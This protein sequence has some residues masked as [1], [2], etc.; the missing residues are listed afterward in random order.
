MVVE[1]DSAL[2]GKE[3]AEA[4]FRESGNRV[5]EGFEELLVLGFGEGKEAGALED[6]EEGEGDTCG[7]VFQNVSDDFKL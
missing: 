7:E 4:F 6:D 3:G 1:F 5:G 2:D